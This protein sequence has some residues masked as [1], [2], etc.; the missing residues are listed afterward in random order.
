MGEFRTLLAPLED[1]MLQAREYTL[2]WKMDSSGNF[3]VQSLVKSLN[4]SPNISKAL[5]K[6]SSEVKISKEGGCSY[7]NFTKW[8]CKYSKK[9]ANEIGFSRLAAFSLCFVYESK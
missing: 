4:N 9:V 6:S 8:R 1:S 3:T 5:L 7:M 2:I